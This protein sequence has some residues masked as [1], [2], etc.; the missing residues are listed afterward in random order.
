LSNR[1]KVEQL[2]LKN[3]FIKE[4]NAE[5]LTLIN[6]RLTES[7]INAKEKLLSVKER[8]LNQKYNDESFNTDI[9]KLIQLKDT[10]KN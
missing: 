9:I 4:M 8:L 6:S 10:L 2:A 5:C 3:N 1:T 7:D